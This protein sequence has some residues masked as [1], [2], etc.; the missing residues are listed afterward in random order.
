MCYCLE[1]DLDFVEWFYNLILINLSEFFSD[2]WGRGREG[3]VYGDCFFFM[4]RR[5]V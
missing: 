1:L 5:K 4:S 2:L 3:I